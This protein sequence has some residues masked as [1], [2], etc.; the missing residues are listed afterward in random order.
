M[1]TKYSGRTA[2]A[3]CIGMAT[4]GWAGVALLV[5]IVMSVAA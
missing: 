5:Q 3:T 4:I 1:H 2:I